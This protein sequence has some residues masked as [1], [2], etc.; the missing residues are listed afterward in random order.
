MSD[1]AA[2]RVAVLSAAWGSGDETA[3]ATRVLA[4]AASRL[5]PVDVFR[6]APPGGVPDGAFDPRGVGEPA[7]G[8]SWPADGVVPPADPAAYRAVLVDAG[9][10]EGAVLASSLL[11]GVPALCPG[12]AAVPGIA[13]RLDLGP[14][15]GDVDLGSDGGRGAALASV[16]LHVPVQALAA[17][18]PHHE[19]GP[20]AGYVLVLSGRGPR[21]ADP[22]RPPAEVAW[23]VAR[24]PR[25]YVVTVENA[26]AAVWRSR[27]CVRRFDV[28]TRMDLWRLMAHSFAL[29][30]LRPGD[31]FARE[32]VE[33]LAY[34][35]PVVV[36][37]GSA[38]EVLAARGAGITF[39]G[40][41]GLL[42]AVSAL[43]DAGER[44][45]VAAAGVEVAVTWYGDPQ[46][47]VRRLGAVF[48]RVQV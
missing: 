16:G 43:S 38:A 15:G 1:R 29:V 3:F 40:I 30:D 2:A 34:G 17:E 20:V 41:A 19:L 11:P 13:L 6:P 18:R 39:A 46:G 42:G 24:F 23:L 48:D 45:R 28:H 26:V 8:Y 31:L 22:D 5:G 12:R 47:L 36:P 33:S 10:R 32:C 9:D 27:S 21:D 25:R 4:G 14:G 35:V 7:P 44:A 37:E